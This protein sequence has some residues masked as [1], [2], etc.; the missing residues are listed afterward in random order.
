MTGEARPRGRFHDHHSHASLYASFMGLPDV[1]GLSRP[2]ALS[3]LAALPE[4]RLSI[5]K[6]WRTDRLALA[7]ADLEPLPPL[8]LVNASLHGF[9]ASPRA[10]PFIEE[11]WPE[12]AERLGDAAWGE[13]N[14][15]RL[16]VF[17]GRV[18]G[19]DAK[20][21]ALFMS[22]LEG[23]GIG[24]VEDM[25]VSGA[26][27]IDLYAAPPFA[28]RILPWA[29]PEVF[30]EL[31]AERK[32]ACAGVKLFLD[33]SL[34]AR[35]AALDAPFSDG[36]EG[37]LL[38]SD[39][40]LAEALAALAR[41]RAAL[42]AHAIGHRAIAQALGALERLRSDG[43][44]FPSVRLEHV[45]FIDEAQA[46]L[47][48]ERGIVLSMQPNFNSDSIDYADRL[49]PRHRA[50]NDPFRML[51]DAVGFKPGVDLLFGS[52]GMPHGIDEALRSALE[53]A[54]PGQRL[55]R[56]EVE[57]GYALDSNVR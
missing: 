39:D 25:T 16:F 32:A 2:E 18:A 9:A 23:L 57:A 3:L 53:C 43:V 33:G 11:M 8:V 12:M 4:D 20:K 46:R 24:S 35:S 28:G 22:A 41:G 42:S 19:L 17:Y 27:A 49:I 13:R 7:P 31:S 44:E 48:R 55:S 15:P 21:L 29:T 37:Q 34:G 52:D 36:R 6:G 26:K 54:Y 47:C 40:E 5:A 1:G 30:E 51:I 14:L 38:Y 45:Q 10:V 50:E 56:A